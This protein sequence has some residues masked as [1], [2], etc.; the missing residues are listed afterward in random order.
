MRYAS[1]PRR[2]AAILIDYGILIPLPVVAVF[3]SSVRVIV[4]LYAVDV[5]LLLGNRWALAGYNGRTFG[6]T[7]MRIKLVG[8]KSRKPIGFVAAF[9]RD[10]CHAIDS[11]A[12][13]L[14][15]IRPLWRHTHQTIAD[16]IVGSVVVPE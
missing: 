15:W 4:I 7:V 14:G 10:A 13:G 1:W 5:L 8:A 11:L 2:A 12:L 16:S 6:R 9:T 3:M